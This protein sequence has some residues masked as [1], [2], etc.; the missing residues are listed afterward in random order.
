MNAAGIFR[1]VAA[2]GAR[3][4]TGRIGHIIEAVMSN[5][6]RKLRV[7]QAGLHAGDAVLRI[8]AENLAHAGQFD[9]HA[10]IDRQ[11]AARQSGAGASR[12]EADTFVQ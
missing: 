5:C 9:H 10:A 1:N 8:D 2:D 3:R 11:S 7:D 6:A 4:L 12:S